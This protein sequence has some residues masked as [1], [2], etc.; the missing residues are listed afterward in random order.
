MHQHEI[1]QPRPCKICL[2]R[3]NTNYSWSQTVDDQIESEIRVAMSSKH[4]KFLQKIKGA[5]FARSP[6]S[7]S[8]TP[9]LPPSKHN[10][11]SRAT[12]APAMVDDAQDSIVS[13]TL[14][15]SVAI[16]APA[17]AQPAAS[18]HLTQ[19]PSEDKPADTSAGISTSVLPSQPRHRSKMEHLD[20]NKESQ[21]SAPDASESGDLWD[22]AYKHLSEESPGLVENYEKILALEE[23]ESNR[24]VD[25][26]SSMVSPGIGQARRRL[27]DLSSQK[28]ACLDE[29][30]LK[31]RVGSKTM[32][33]R[34]GMDKV[35]TAVISAKEFVSGAL[36]SEPHAAI[37][38]RRSG[39]LAVLT[40]H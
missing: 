3:A 12:S 27:A 26:Q 36:V 16:S 22:Q 7:Q 6:R 37:A 40:G 29:S 4:P 18:H 2:R 1:S 39:S 28:L 30:R 20:Q 15:Y 17:E 34:D 10:V 8:P 35:L 19:F 24:S 33:L 32:V 11:P 13:S 23:S 5:V 14:S 25:T 31:I 9:V 38:V 21:Y